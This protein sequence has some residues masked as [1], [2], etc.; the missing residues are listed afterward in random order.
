MTIWHSRKLR[1]QGHDAP[2][3]LGRGVP[4]HGLGKRAEQGA[5]PGRRSCSYRSGA[6]EHSPAQLRADRLVGRRD[7]LISPNWKGAACNCEQATGSWQMTSH[8]VNRTIT[9]E[10]SY[11]NNQ[12]F[13][14]EGNA[15]WVRT[16]VA[17]QPSIAIAS[18]AA[19][20]PTAAGA[21]AGTVHVQVD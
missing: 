6:I 3:W 9:R 14:F 21:E 13:N 4:L 20:I 1:E 8:W 19:Q 7:Y 5:A 10:K 16:G 15:K 18:T 17:V 12:R 11:G 2:R